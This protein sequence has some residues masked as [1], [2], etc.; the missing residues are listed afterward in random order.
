MEPSMSKKKKVYVIRT[1]SELDVIC[2]PV[3]A[4]IL[5]TLIAFGPLPIREIAQHIGRPVNLTHHH[6][7]R[8]VSV[9]FVVE[10]KSIKRGR[11]RERI[12]QL[13][14][15]DF[16]FDFESHPQLAAQGMMRLMKTF[17]RYSERML[18]RALQRGITPAMKELISFRCETA[19]LSFRSIRQVLAHLAA[20]RAIFER[21][22]ARGTGEAFQIFWSC[23][24]LANQRP[25]RREGRHA[26]R[27][28]DLK[29]F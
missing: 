6:V 8:L 11:H 25:K 10:Q 29:D 24:P 27:M 4:A 9:G 7:N 2:S 5:E 1:A 21:Q 26:P 14:F 3:R 16:R 12:F 13:P 19:R 18:G 15:A 17:G 20:I 28:G 22:R 23:Y